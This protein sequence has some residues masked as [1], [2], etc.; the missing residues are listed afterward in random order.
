ML[1]KEIV[2]WVPRYNKV[3]KGLDVGCW[4][5]N[6]KPNELRKC[7]TKGNSMVESYNKL[8]VTRYNKVRKGSKSDT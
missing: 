1:P 7:D 3:P 6:V 4:I 5:L 2:W 8:Q